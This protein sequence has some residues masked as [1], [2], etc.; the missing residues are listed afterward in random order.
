MLKYRILIAD[1]E[2]NIREGLKEVL[3][4]DYDVHTVSSGKEAIK[5]LEKIEYDLILTD[6]KMGP[7]TGAALLRHVVQNYRSIP[8]IILTGHGTVKNAV[9]ALHKGAFDYLSKPLNMGQLLVLVK[10]ALQSRVISLRN[11]QINEELKEGRNDSQIITKSK[12][13]LHL[14]ENVKLIAP[15]NSV[16]LVTGESGVGKEVFCNRIHQLSKRRDKPF[17]SVH[18]ASLTESLLESELFGH[19]KG[20]FTGAVSQRKGRFELAD[21]GTIFLDEIGEIDKSIQVKLLRVLQERTFERVGGEESVKVDVRII[22]ATNKDLRKEVELGNFREDLYYRLSVV[23]VN[24]P[25][26]SERQEDVLIFAQ[27]FLKQFS[28]IHEKNIEGFS[29]KALQIFTNYVWP[30]NIRELR[31]CVESSVIIARSKLIEVKDLPAYLRKGE[32]KKGIHVALGTSLEEL[33]K[34]YIQSM[35]EFFE[36]N[37]SKTA[38]ALG[39]GRKTLHNKIS[40]YMLT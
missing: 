36:G 32:K 11:R 2:K 16:V 12:K 21:K 24:I 40:K 18:C 15:T 27:S 23:H 37:K 38:E 28:K 10:K 6:Y 33:E 29:K 7:V 22:T 39:I 20:S 31:N 19:E 26:L 4:E 34:I 1:D 17:I 30:G 25:A 35:L 14:L 5:E 8:V 13:M 9:E 3:E